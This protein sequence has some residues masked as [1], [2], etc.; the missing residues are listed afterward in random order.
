MADAEDG[1]QPWHEGLWF[2]E[3][4]EECRSEAAIAGYDPR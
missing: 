2:V 4:V 1:E 3:P